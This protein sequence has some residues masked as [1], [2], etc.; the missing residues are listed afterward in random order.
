MWVNVCQWAAGCVGVCGFASVD[1]LLV[2]MYVCFNVF[3]CLLC[4]CVMVGQ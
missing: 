3:V 4:L 1:A 2:V